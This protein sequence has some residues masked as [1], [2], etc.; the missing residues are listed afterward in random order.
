[1]C[2]HASDF[3]FYIFQVLPLF[4]SFIYLTTFIKQSSRKFI[5]TFHWTFYWLI[6]WIFYMDQWITKNVVDTIFL[7]WLVICY[8]YLFIKNASRGCFFKQLF[9]VFVFIQCSV[10]YNICSDTPK[11]HINGSCLLA[12][13]K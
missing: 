4:W 2:N 7:A 1:M 8:H 9:C 10:W 5:N 13:L 11:I 12:N 3:F 6:Y